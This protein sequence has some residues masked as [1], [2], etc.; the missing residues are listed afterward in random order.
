MKTQLEALKEVLDAAKKA[1]HAARVAYKAAEATE[2]ETYLKM[3]G[4]ECAY[5]YL[6]AMEEV[7]AKK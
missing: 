1:H 7:A 4:A 2:H 5:E 3:L 6:A